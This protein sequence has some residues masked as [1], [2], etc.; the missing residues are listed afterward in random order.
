MRPLLLSDA[1]MEHDNSLFLMVPQVIYADE[2][3]SSTAKMILAEILN[4]LRV[5]RRFCFAS[6]EHFAQLLGLKKNNVSHHIAQLEGL[7]WV[8]T[9]SVSGCQLDG[10]PLQ[11]KGNHRHIYPGKPLSNILDTLSKKTI[12]PPRKNVSIKDK[13]KRSSKI[14]A[15]Q[16]TTG[17]LDEVKKQDQGPIVITTEYQARAQEIETRLKT[18]PRYRPSLIAVCRDKPRPVIDA[19]LTYT[20]DYPN[21]RDPALVFLKRVHLLAK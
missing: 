11:Q 18:E 2:D 8:V 10:C 3:M 1:H 15:K 5:E 16:S 17:S 9:E 6:N 13:Y 21:A 14:S 7:G 4:K 20:I 12:E 19:A